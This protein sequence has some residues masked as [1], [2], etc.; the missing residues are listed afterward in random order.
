MRRDME[1]V[2][3]LL[4]D[5]SNG[6]YK[7]V[8]YKDDYQSDQS[9]I[10]EAEKYIYHLEILRDGGFIAFKQVSTFE[11][12]IITD[13]PK[14]TW[15]GNDFLDAIENDTIWEKTKDRAKSQGFEL[16]KMSLDLV[17]SLAVQQAKQ[18]L[19]IE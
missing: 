8:I 10:E 1:Y 12:N 17:K 7:E 14:L 16:A 5:L 6:K 11:A 18:L 2:R 15:S 4:I 19:N 9:T 3:D 13:T